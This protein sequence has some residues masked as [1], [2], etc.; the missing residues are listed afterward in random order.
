MECSQL[1][2]QISRFRSQDEKT[3]VYNGCVCLQRLEGP[4][5]K[6][7]V[8]PQGHLKAK[9][10]ACVHIPSLRIRCTA[11]Q[12]SQ[13]QLNI[14]TLQQ[15]S[16]LS[17]TRPSSRLMTDAAACVSSNGQCCKSK[18]CVVSSVCSLADACIVLSKQD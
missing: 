13:L 12:S 8:L 5:V 11:L 17:A 16:T 7:I 4:G 14:N 6:L 15:N 3:P 10:A 9:E 2:F 1:D 18:C